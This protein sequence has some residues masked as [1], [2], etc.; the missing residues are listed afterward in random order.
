MKVAIL[1]AAG[2][3]G[4]A[5]IDEALARG[6]EVIGIARNPEKILSTDPRVIK[7][8]GDAFVESEIVAALE[9]AEAV[10]TTVGKTDLRDKRINLSTAAH[11]SVIAG[12]R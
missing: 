5:L 7:R 9:S 1:G 8:K 2:Q 4:T 3:T 11:Q 6:H 12:M 10:I